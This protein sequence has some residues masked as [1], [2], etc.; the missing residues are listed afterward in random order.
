MPCKHAYTTKAIITI[1]ST[2]QQILFA[3]PDMHDLKNRIK[4][5][6]YYFSDHHNAYIQ[7]LAVNTRGIFQ[8]K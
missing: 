7:L 2:L 4:C 1:S 8:T 3:K 5:I 6:T